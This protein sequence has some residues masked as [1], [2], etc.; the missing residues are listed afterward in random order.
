MLEENS[1]PSP[2]LF[3]RH[4]EQDQNLKEQEIAPEGFSS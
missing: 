4:R 2:P 1:T 3:L